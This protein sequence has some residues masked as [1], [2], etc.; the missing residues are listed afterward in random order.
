MSRGLGDVYKR[1]L[2]INEAA[3]GP[4]HPDVA[5]TL[6]NLAITLRNLGGAENLAEACAALLRALKIDE[7]ALGPD[8]PNV[9]ID[10]GLIAQMCAQIGGAE[11]MALAREM[12]ARSVRIFEARLGPDHPHTH[13]A[14]H[15]RD[16]E[17]GDREA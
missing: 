1:Q 7:V 6:S 15:I 13:T 8:H 11:N 5:I 4:D 12:A 2:K 10:C 16:V 14:R 3:F 9:A 17:V